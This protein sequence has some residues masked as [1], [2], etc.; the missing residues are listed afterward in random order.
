M[1]K[2]IGL[3]SGVMWNQR[4]IGKSVSSHTSTTLALCHAKCCLPDQPVS[5]TNCMCIVKPMLRL[6][7]TQNVDEL[8]FV[9]FISQKMFF[10]FTQQHVTMKRNVPCHITSSAFL[11]MSCIFC[12]WSQLFPSKITVEEFLWHTFELENMCSSERS[13]F[14]LSHD[15][16]LYTLEGAAGSKASDCFQTWGAQWPM[17]QQN[18]GSFFSK[19]RVMHKYTINM[20]QT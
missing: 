13:D 18:K 5:I 16:R 9:V 1:W 11:Q 7:T 8:L 17:G 14:M 12:G 6:T 2:D 15:T 4:R 3:C 19:C 10:G 20:N